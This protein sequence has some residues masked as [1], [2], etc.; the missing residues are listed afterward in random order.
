MLYV[1]MIA[2]GAFIGW[3]T[4]VVAIWLLFHP[5]DPIYVGPWHIQ[6]LLPRR[7]A[8]IARSIGQLIEKNLFNPADLKTLLQ[9]PSFYDQLSA[10]I[11]KTAQRELEKRLPAY[12]PAVIRD[13]LSDY[14]KAWFDARS[15]AFANEIV[16]DLPLGQIDVGLLIESKLRLM[17]LREFEVLSREVV[18]REL[19][20]IE[21]AGGVL[22]GVV[23]L[24]QAIFISWGK[25]MFF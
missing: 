4:N 23:G 13:H 22:G 24:L 20:Y 3:V 18:G 15:I 7:Q 12:L 21:L 25:V 6:G 1:V 10:L 2:T 19:K 9:K 11:S 14:C 17:S 16:E 5:Y 8:D